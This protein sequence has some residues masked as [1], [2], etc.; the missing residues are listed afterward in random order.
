[1]SLDRVISKEEIERVSEKTASPLISHDCKENMMTRVQ[2]EERSSRLYH[3]MS[4]WCNSKGFFGAASLYAEYSEEEMKHAAWAKEYLLALDIQPIL[5]EIKPT[6]QTWE[7]LPETI[8][9][10]YD[11]EVEIYT[12]CKGLAAGA[13]SD[14]DFGLYELSLQYCKEQIE[15]I[16]KIQDLK[17]QLEAFGTDKVALRLLD[18]KMEV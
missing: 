12:Q 9:D 2:E 7:G 4:L 6:K 10:A 5:R 11:H 13:L 1:M 18:S 16:G 14:N 8:S 3:A 17:D 15:E